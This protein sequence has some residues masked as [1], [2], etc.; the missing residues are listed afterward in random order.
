LF[1]TNKKKKKTLLFIDII[2]IKLNNHNIE[3]NR[4]KKTKNI[5]RNFYIVWYTYN[6]T[7]SKS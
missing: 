2:S 4:E 5:K 3:Q 7:L 1:A 6:I